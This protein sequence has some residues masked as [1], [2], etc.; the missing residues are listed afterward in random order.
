MLVRLLRVAVPGG[1]VLMRSRRVLLRIFVF[2]SVM[3][4]GCL[5]VMVSSRLMSGRSRMMVL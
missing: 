1:A 5:P 2:A 3:V 4:V